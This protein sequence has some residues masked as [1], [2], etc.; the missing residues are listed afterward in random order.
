MP[1]I[2]LVRHGKAAAGFGDH[3]DPGLDDLGWQQ[4]EKAADQLSAL[5]PM[6]LYSS[7]LARARET[8]IPLARRWEVTPTIEPRVAEIPSPT[9][10]L[11]E[12]S[13]WLRQV[14]Q[15]RWS[16]LPQALNQWRQN[17]IDCLLD[18]PDDSIVFCHFIAINV[19][20]GHA[21]GED[22][23]IVFRPDNA[24]ITRFSTDSGKLELRQLGQEAD[25]RVN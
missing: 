6:A 22:Q 11:Q 19:A 12:R 14:M 23:M 16:N 4:A 18:L 24:S 15:E 2:Y 17:L 7:P 20:V 25:T 21:R 8:A 3:L 9:T 10:D 5:T 1:S 13:I